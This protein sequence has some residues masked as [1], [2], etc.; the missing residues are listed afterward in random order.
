M[1][2]LRIPNTL[3]IKSLEFKLKKLTNSKEFKQILTDSRKTAENWA[4]NQV[5]E[6]N[7]NKGSRY[8]VL[9]QNHVYRS[10]LQEFFNLY[11]NR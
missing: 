9:A 1:N 7:Y 2:K 5:K 11:K 10:A 6:S 4:D 3:P 8:L